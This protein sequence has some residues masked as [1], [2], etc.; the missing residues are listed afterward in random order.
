MDRSS[1]YNQ[2]DSQGRRMTQLHPRNCSIY[3]ISLGVM[4]ANHAGERVPQIALRFD[5]L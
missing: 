5:F 1:S 3:W 2:P 4:G